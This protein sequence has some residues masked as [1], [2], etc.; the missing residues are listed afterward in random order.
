MTSFPQYDHYVLVS[1]DTLRSD[2]IAA[3]PL[4]L[5]P[6][7]HAGQ[8]PPS[9]PL[10]D[11]MVAEGTFL[12]NAISAAPYTSA[13]HATLLTGRWPHRHGV[14]EFF[15]RRLRGETLFTWAR[16]RGL[17]T[18]FKSDFP[19]IL[20]EHLGFTDD[21]DEY[22]VEDD[23]EY[24]SRLDTTSPSL[25]FLH[26]GSLHIPYGFHNLRYGGD[27]YRQRVAE[28]SAGIPA[29]GAALG[30]RLVETYRSGEDLELLLAYKRIVLHHYES[31]DYETLFSLYLE[32]VETFMRTRFEPF[33][34]R[35]MERMQGRRVLVV[36][37]GDHGEEYDASSYG[38]FNTMAEG[39]TR[40]PVL[41]W[42]PGVSAGTHRE[43]IRT[44]D[45]AP[46]IGAV[47]GGVQERLD[48]VPLVETVFGGAAPRPRE[49]YV[50]AHVSDTAQF[51]DFQQ[52]LLESGRKPGSLPHV[53]YAEAVYD[54]DIKLS[55][56]N[57]VY[58]GGPVGTWSL[59]PCEPRI[60]VER[61]DTDLVPRRDEWNDEAARALALLDAYGGHFEA[62]PDG[63]GDGDPVV[64][65]EIRS[66]LRNM[67]YRI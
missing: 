66:Q 26:F 5:W 57:Y 29:G 13:A 8:K 1:L 53:C 46:T 34:E 43:R 21:V 48:G 37:F 36:L 39:V 6:T 54:G 10:L 44:V 3:N 4:K 20:G 27:A 23:D 60:T 56:Q 40:V 45:V 64:T 52:K 25:S 19:I 62:G 59:A 11:R 31:G 2:A 67:G 30:D 38:H 51:V 28:L 35:L 9:T 15:N 7:T 42:G 58:T 55:R 18:Y 49:A 12:P 47:L 32:G 61:F 16:R 22:V 33:M 17:R 24:F 50:Q 63:S 65:D 14:F 41:F